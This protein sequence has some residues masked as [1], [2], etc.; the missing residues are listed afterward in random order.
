MKKLKYFLIA[1]CFLSC[2]K[3]T[4]TP[5]FRPWLFGQWNWYHSKN[6][7]TVPDTP[8]STGKTW[9]LEFKEDLT[10]VQSGTRYP[11]SQGTYSYTG[12]TIYINYSHENFQRRFFYYFTSKD[13]LVL[14]ANS[15]VDGPIHYLV[16]K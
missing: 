10:V 4:K 1:I 13:S 11:V 12:N 5:E 2:K 15:M 6:A 16:R 8:Q 14:D 7:F 3:D 9:V